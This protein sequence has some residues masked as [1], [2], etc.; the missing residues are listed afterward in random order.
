[1]SESKHS[2]GPYEVRRRFDIYAKSGTYLGTTRGNGPLPESIELVDE[3][4]AH[5]FA[6]S[7]GLLKSCR[8]LISNLDDH[9]CGVGDEYPALIAI[10]VAK[11]IID[12]I[13]KA[14]GQSDEPH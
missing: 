2:P 6:A 1:M 3:A 7:Y 10:A 8:E 14:K 11:T 9:L 5:L 13:E 12:E 4:N